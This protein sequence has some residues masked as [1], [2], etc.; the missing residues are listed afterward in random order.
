LSEDIIEKVKNTSF[1]KWCYLRGNTRVLIDE[2]MQVCP[3]PAVMPEYYKAIL[4][5]GR[6]L[7]VSVWS[8]TQRPKTIP[9]SII[10][11]STHFF[12]F[13]LNLEADRRR[14]NEVVT[15]PEIIDYIPEKYQFW[16]YKIGMARPVLG[17]LN[18]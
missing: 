2:A 15:Y 7:N 1:F 13:M 11:E 14:V 6:E 5:R 17:R 16:Y 4:T 10:S 3:N 18:G 12:I 9:L 8:C